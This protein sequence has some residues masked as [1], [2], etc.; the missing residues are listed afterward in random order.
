MSAQ[1][2]RLAKVPKVYFVPFENI[3][4]NISFPKN[5]AMMPNLFFERMCGSKKHCALSCLIA[6]QQ[7]FFTGSKS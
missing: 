1:F 7:R 2:V 4:R 6:F 3:L 5:D